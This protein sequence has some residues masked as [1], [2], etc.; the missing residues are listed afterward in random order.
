MDG[1]PRTRGSSVDGGEKERWTREGIWG[2]KLKL[3][4]IMKVIERELANNGGKKH[5]WKLL[6]QMGPMGTPKTTGCCQHCKL[7]LTHSWQGPAA[8]DSTYVTHC[9]WKVPGGA[10]TGSS[11]L[12][13]ITFGTERNYTCYQVRNVNTNPAYKPFDLQWSPACE[14]VVPWWGKA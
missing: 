1:R 7:F 5:H 14:M 12:H 6:C 13:T 4:A 2:E 3:R 8:E 11:P 10:Y 9:V